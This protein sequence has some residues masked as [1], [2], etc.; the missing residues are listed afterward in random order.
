M[1]IKV[2][3]L[4]YR[5]N[6]A[7]VIALSPDYVGFVFYRNSPRDVSCERELPAYA[8]SMRHVKKVGVF[9]NESIPVILQAVAAYGLDM[10]Q[11]HGNE[12]PAF[13]ASLKQSIAVMKAFSVSDQ[14]DFK[15][16]H[17]YE[18]H[19]NY[20]LF[21]TPTVAYGGSGRVFDWQLLYDRHIVLPFFLSGG[22]GPE[23][24]NQALLVQNASLAGLDLNSRVERSPGYKDIQKLQTVIHELRTK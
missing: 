11:L 18:Q 14:F 3:G 13:C 6:I 1:Q 2:C 20:F 16:L 23:N 5:D 22:I 21:D 24:F 19:C 9:V 10:V 8:R 17:P 7:Q 15:Q 4:K 12:T